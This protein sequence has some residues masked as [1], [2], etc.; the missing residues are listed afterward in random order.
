MLLTL[1]A[2]LFLAPFSVRAA[3]GAFELVNVDSLLEK[4]KIHNP[5]ENLHDFSTDENGENH[6]FLFIDS[7]KNVEV[8]RN[9]TMLYHGTLPWSCSISVG[10]FIMTDDGHVLFT[11]DCKTLYVDTK[12]MNSDSKMSVGI[13]GGYS[14]RNGI[15]YYL[16]KNAVMQFDVKTKA[17]KMLFRHPE[18]LLWLEMQGQN[19]MYLGKRERGMLKKSESSGF[20]DTDTVKW[21]DLKTY[22]PVYTVYVNGKSVG[23]KTG[24]FPPNA[25]GH[26]GMPF[27]T[28]ETGQSFNIYAGKSIYKKLDQYGGIVVDDFGSVWLYSTDSK[29]SQSSLIRDGQTLKLPRIKDFAFLTSSKE[30]FSILGLLDSD[31]SLYEV[32]LD[33]EPIGEPVQLKP[34]L[35]INDQISIGDDQHVYIRSAT[36]DNIGIALDNGKR[37]FQKDFKHIWKLLFNNGKIFVYGSN[38]IPK[39]YE[40]QPNN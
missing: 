10:A 20:K 21:G 9:G 30:H 25:L 6:A 33:G 2:L 19:L 40:M 26:D 4:Y 32:I 1:F 14:Y 31:S 36:K 38:T 18:Q 34:W 28:S 24:L 11:P 16:S 8:F 22:A 15:V 12:S 37:V 35:S 5:V 3:S 29:T 39:Y 17:K 23:K 27:F 7:Q 13:Q